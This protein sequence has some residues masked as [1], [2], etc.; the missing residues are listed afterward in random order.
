MKKILSII[1]CLVLVCSFSVTAFAANATAS[2][3]GVPSEIKKDATANIT[4]NVSGT[5]TLSS[6][7]VHVTLGDGLELVSGEWKKDGIM[8]DFTVSNG[9]GVIAFSG[10][11]TMDGTVFSFVVKGKTV[12]QTAQNI[13]VDLTFKSGSSVVGTTSASKTVKVACVSHTYGNYA[14][15]N[16]TN[17]TRTC[18]ACGHT[19][20][21][22]HTWNGGTVTKA[23]TCKEAGVKTYTCTAC[24]ATK[25]E[26]IAKTNSHN[27]SGYKVTKQPTCTAAGTQTR[28]CSVCG[29]TESQPVAEKG[30]SW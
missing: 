1:I 16:A 24:N 19:E 12:S 18:S 7:L 10:A 15:A 2:L 3:G 29:E 20:T 21:A 25:T 8:K 26:T 14:N 5:P 30:H 23:A 11:G 27:W 22:N 17:H 9:Y 28:T 4:V 6:A 13:K